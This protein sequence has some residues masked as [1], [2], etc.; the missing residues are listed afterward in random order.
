MRFGISATSLIVPKNLRTRLRPVNVCA[1]GCSLDSIVAAARAPLLTAA[2]HRDHRDRRRGRPFLCDSG[3]ARTRSLTFL[4]ERPESLFHA[5]TG[6][7][8]TPAA[9]I[10]WSNA[11]GP[12]A[13]G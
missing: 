10:L 13:Q 9:Y 11:P 8:P 6:S 3:R 12:K 5:L 7:Q 4:R 1:I 2:I